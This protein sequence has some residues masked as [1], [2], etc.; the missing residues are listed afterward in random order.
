VIEIA[1]VLGLTLNMDMTSL[2][3]SGMAVTRTRVNVE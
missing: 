2:P 3:S 1:P